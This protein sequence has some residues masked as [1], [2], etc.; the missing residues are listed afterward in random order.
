R[1]TSG[2]DLSPSA[3]RSSTASE[4]DCR[5][6]LL[7][8]KFTPSSTRLFFDS[9]ITGARAA[10]GADFSGQPCVS[11]LV[12]RGVSG[13]L[14]LSSVTPSPSLSAGQPSLPTLVPRGVFGHL[15]AESATPSPSESCE[16]PL[17]STR[18]PAGVSGH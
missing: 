7:V 17:L 5:W 15:S 11:T 6:A 13:H 3:T 2:W 12:P 18:V 4:D 10:A 1:R 8:S 14:S 9:G 16:Q